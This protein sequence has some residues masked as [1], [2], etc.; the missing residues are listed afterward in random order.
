MAR[1]G[2]RQSRRTHLA[3]KTVPGVVALACAAMQ[4]PAN[5]IEL[6]A[7][8]F[9]FDWAATMDGTAAHTNWR[10]A[11]RAIVE[12]RNA[13]LSFAAALAALNADAWQVG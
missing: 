2:R 4:T 12:A 6:A 7:S 10:A 11:D 1:A 9:A 13:Q 3:L 5:A 8:G